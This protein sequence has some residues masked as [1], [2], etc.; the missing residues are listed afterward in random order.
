MS[1]HHIPVMLEQ[2]VAALNIKPDGVYLDGTAG[3]GG[4]SLEIA[5]RLTTGRLICTD[6]DPQAVAAATQRLKP[7]PVA[8]VVQEDFA[9]F[10]GVLD[11]LGVDALDG[12][13]LDLGISSHQ[14]D[15][16]E[17]GFSYHQD[18]PLDMRMSSSGT[19]AAQLLSEAPEE[20]LAG[21]FRK[22]GEERFAGR[23]A[24]NIV[25]ARETQPIETTAQ[26][27][28]IIRSSIPAPAR[29]EG[30]HPAKRVFQ[31]LRIS[32]NG[33]LDSLSTCLDTAFDRLTPGGRFAVI[34]F[35][36]LEDRMVKQAFAALAKGCE[37]PPGFPICV[38]GKQPRGELV[39][40]KPQLATP[41]ELAANPRAK[42]AKLRTIEK[43]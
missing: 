12:I 8:Q 10:A 40:R 32:I 13:L 20:T 37:C 33:E 41:E 17:R 25:L 21:I 42:S 15:T 14:V 16:P 4:H 35:H 6:K 26:L 34:T 23:I 31:A 38:C 19:T 28:E 5:K 18:A 24:R 30:G 2:A 43:L 3:G 7:Y 27:A 9:D 11:D 39:G 22:Y 1:F 29:R 36:S